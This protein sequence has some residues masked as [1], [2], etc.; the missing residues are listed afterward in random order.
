MAGFSLLLP[1]RPGI[2]LHRRN[3]V[4]K[5]FWLLCFKQCLPLYKVTKKKINTV[6]NLL[7]ITLAVFCCNFTFAQDIKDKT[8]YSQAQ[9]LDTSISP[10]FYEV[11]VTASEY[12]EYPEKKR[13]S[14]AIKIEMD[15]VKK[16]LLAELEKI[17]VKDNV[18][19]SKIVDRDYQS[20]TAEA[21][22]KISYRFK[23]VSRDSVEIIYKTMIKNMPIASLRRFDVTP[24]LTPA[25][26]K[27]AQ[28]ELE[29]I[30]LARAKND[31]QKFAE[32]NKLSLQNIENYEVEFS[33]K[34]NYEDYYNTQGK[35]LNISFLHLVYTLTVKHTFLL[36]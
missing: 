12:Y 18:L 35:S 17:G 16:M 26:I 30:A 27:K 36:N 5:I 14:K 6:I 4:F 28:T 22:L 10:D 33:R 13:N 19:L 20:Y 1:S 15:S 31:A 3:L 32:E 23:V 2:I 25:T 9:S 11:E 21:L 24:V 7:F 29:I 8:R 34:Y